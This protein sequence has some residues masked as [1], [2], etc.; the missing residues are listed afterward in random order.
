MANFTVHGLEAL[1][2]ATSK[3][4]EIPRDVTENILTKMGRVL[5]F[6]VQ[7]RALA[8]HIWDTGEVVRAIFLKDPEITSEGG[9]ITVTF[10]GSRK[11][12]KTTTRNAEIAF[13]NEYGKKGQ[14][15]RPFV[16]EARE[17]GENE[18]EAAG[19]D[20]L[21]SWLDKIGL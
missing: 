17:M 14:D 9:S 16:K 1:Y 15:G 7:K 10:K 18:T 21:N 13:I 20:A 8:R 5:E 11:R 2:E 3:A 12:G 6:W 4:K 19:Q